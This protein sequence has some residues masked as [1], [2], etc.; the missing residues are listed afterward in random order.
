MHSTRRVS[1]EDFSTTFQD[2]K[3]TPYNDKTEN[4]L[5]DVV[6]DRLRIEMLQRR[7]ILAATESNTQKSKP[8]K[9]ASFST[10]KA[11][12]KNLCEKLFHHNTAKK[13][14]LSLSSSDDETT[15]SSE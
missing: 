3:A 4:F 6:A 10:V 8:K 12:F 13:T 5:P 7:I 9:I 15:T 14:S 1:V 11:A 2:S